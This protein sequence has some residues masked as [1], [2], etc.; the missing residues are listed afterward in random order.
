MGVA[1]QLLNLCYT[2]GSSNAGSE[3]G[4]SNVDCVCSMVDSFAALLVVLGWGE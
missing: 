2:V 4:G 1:G 3:I